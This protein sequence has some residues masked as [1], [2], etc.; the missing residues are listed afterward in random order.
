MS[1]GTFAIVHS[2]EEKKVGSDS[3]GT[4]ANGATSILLED[5]DWASE[6]GGKLYINGIHPDFNC[7]AAYTGVNYDTNTLTGVSGVA[8]GPFDDNTP[9]EPRPRQ[10]EKYAEVWPEGAEFEDNPE[11]IVCRVHSS[12]VDRLKRGT[13]EQD[14]GERVFIERR[15]PEYVLYEI[16][17]E[18]GDWI[19][20]QYT[21]PRN[22]TDAE[23]PQ[24]SPPYAAVMKEARAYCVWNG[25]ASNLICHLKL[26]DNAQQINVEQIIIPPSKDKSKWV[27][28]KDDDGWEVDDDMMVYCHISGIP[29]GAEGPL[30][31]QVRVQPKGAG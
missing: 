15:G 26:W 9:V 20:W 3:N 29:S 19:I 21:S 8:N 2:V 6:E 22:I 10:W 24:F 28:L 11:P 5:A 30:V 23:G 31:L 16:I 7:E 27:K 4:I 12:L 1:E 17:G 25:G 13:R 14:V 18:Q